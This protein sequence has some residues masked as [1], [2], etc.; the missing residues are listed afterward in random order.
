MPPYGTTT[1]PNDGYGS[2]VFL[3][4]NKIVVSGECPAFGL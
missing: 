4:L 2:L 3:M 1:W